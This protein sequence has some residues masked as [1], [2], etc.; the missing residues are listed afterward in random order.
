MIGSV[1]TFKRILPLPHHTHTCPK[2]M[3]P[4]AAGPLPVCPTP[5]AMGPLPPR[6]HPSPYLPPCP[7]HLQQRVLPLLSHV[8]LDG[9]AGPPSS[10]V[11]RQALVSIL[12]EP[13]LLLLN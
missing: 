7:L 9:L 10:L 6:R 4:A 11:P 1:R 12:P 2:A 13:L 5:A 8:Q 3:A